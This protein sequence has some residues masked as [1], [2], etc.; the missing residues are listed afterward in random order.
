MNRLRI[1]DINS[2]M[3]C[4]DLNAY[5]L[6]DVPR[7]ELEFPRRG[8]VNDGRSCHQSFRVPITNTI[9]DHPVR[10]SWMMLDALTPRKGCIFTVADEMR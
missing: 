9:K 8:L 4:H 10:E 1:D 6:R 7:S 2:K 3:R 5:L